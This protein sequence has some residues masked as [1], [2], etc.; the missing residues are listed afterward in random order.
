M[1]MKKG[2]VGRRLEANSERTK[3][4][5]EYRHVRTSCVPTTNENGF[6]NFRGVKPGLTT[7]DISK[8][9]LAWALGGGFSGSSTPAGEKR[10]G[11]GP[12]FRRGEGVGSHPVSSHR[13]DAGVAEKSEKKIP[14]AFCVS[15]VR[16]QQNA[17]VGQAG[18]QFGRKRKVGPLQIR[19]FDGR[20]LTGP[21][22]GHTSTLLQVRGHF[23]ANRDGS[24][25]GGHGLFVM[26]RGHGTKAKSVR[27]L[28]IPEG[29]S[30]PK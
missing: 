20:L 15:T 23:R 9:R 3:Y 10:A 13:R 5:L 28:E 24:L 17:R 30:V 27:P 25:W 18:F 6:G 21:R 1:V 26:E 29:K 7:C 22:D 19:G 12:R 8:S 4:L 14:G 11:W 2:K 16:T